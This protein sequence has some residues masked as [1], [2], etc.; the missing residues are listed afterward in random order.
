M[1]MRAVL[2]IALLIGGIYAMLETINDYNEKSFDE[3]FESMNAEF[4]SLTFNKPP[5]NG[6]PAET[7]KIIDEVEVDELL[8]FL[9]QYSVKKIK[10]ED[11]DLYGSMDELSI[12]LQDSQGN[13]LTIMVAENLIIQNSA[14]YYEIID[15]PLDMNWIV[16]F[17][18]SNK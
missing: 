6:S 7:W 15:G 10:S 1:K 3:L 12:S 13:S 16:R 11:V 17:I 2:L 4:D 14:F 18:V 8:K 9:Q 5:M